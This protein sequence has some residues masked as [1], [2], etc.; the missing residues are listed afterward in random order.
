M[1]SWLRGFCEHGSSHVHLAAHGGGMDR[2]EVR[3]GAWLVEGELEGVVRGDPARIER[4]VGL[5]GHTNGLYGD[6]TV[7]EN[8]RFWGATVGATR[9]EVFYIIGMK[10]FAPA[11]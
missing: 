6:L 5:L 9:D 4:A 11:F 8:V 2:A 3:V 10:L 7:R 1:T